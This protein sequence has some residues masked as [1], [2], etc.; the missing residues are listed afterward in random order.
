VCVFE[1]MCVCA[2]LWALGAELKSFSR[3]VSPAPN[4]IFILLYFVIFIF[5]YVGSGLCT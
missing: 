3:A 1:C 4:V 2:T 5:N